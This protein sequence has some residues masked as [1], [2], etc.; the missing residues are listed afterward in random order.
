VIR[1]D[2]AVAVTVSTGCEQTGVRGTREPSTRYP[3]GAQTAIA[4]E[5]NVNIGQLSL[6]EVASPQ[7]PDAESEAEPRQQV[8]WVLLIAT[9]GHEVRYELSRPDGQDEHGRVVSWSERIIFD[10]IDTDAL[11]GRQD[12]DDGDAGLDVPVERI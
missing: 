5:T 12:D 2:R 1:P 8:L 10:S 4:V 7:I 6:W 3:K 9:V 11:P